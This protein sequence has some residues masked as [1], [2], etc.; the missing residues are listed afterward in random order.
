MYISTAIV[1]KQHYLFHAAIAAA[2]QVVHKKI[3]SVKGLIH[4]KKVVHK[5]NKCVKGFI[6]NKIFP[7]KIS[8]WNC[9]PCQKDEMGA[10]LQRHYDRE[11]KREVG[12]A[13]RGKGL[14]C[15]GKARRLLRNRRKMRLMQDDEDDEG[16]EESSIEEEEMIDEEVEEDLGNDEVHDALS[17]G[18]VMSS[19]TRVPVPQV[20][21]ADDSQLLSALRARQ[22]APRAGQLGAGGTVVVLV[23]SGAQDDE[24][25]EGEE[26]SSLEE[27][28]MID[29][30]VEEDL[31]NDEVH[32]ALSAGSVMSSG[33]RVPVPQV[34]SADDSQLLSALRAVQTAPRAGQLGAGGE[35][36]RLVRFTLPCFHRANIQTGDQLCSGLLTG[37]DIE[38]NCCC[39]KNTIHKLCGG[40][41]YI[42]KS[43]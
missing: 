16:E 10:G 7:V 34:E 42:E 21:S 17:A 11:R 2:G 1:D 29:E 32:D 31:G 12:N 18:S 23:G 36:V 33:T 6:H 5:K 13:R 3:K 41:F 8:I 15:P 27:E 14:W 20:E 28:E 4:N 37:T 35:R 24:D 26:E 40:E 25:D 22:T 43:K 39:E 19:G 38:H 9:P 30:E